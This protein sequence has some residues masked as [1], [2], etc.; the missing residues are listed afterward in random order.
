ADFEQARAAGQGFL[1]QLDS[2]SF[3]AEM[4]KENSFLTALKEQGV[5]LKKQIDQAVAGFMVTEKGNR[6]ALMLRGNFDPAAIK[7]AFAQAFLVVD[8]GEEGGDVIFIYKNMK[9][10]SLTPPL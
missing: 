7:S 6:Y 1:E 5:D 10:C 8:N 4:T 9:T 2:L 3:P